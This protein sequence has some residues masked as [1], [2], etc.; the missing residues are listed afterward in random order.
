MMC[1]SSRRRTASS[2][3][4]D[5]PAALLLVEHPS[6]RAVLAQVP[7]LFIIGHD[8]AG[9][10]GERQGEKILPLLG[11]AAVQM[12]LRGQLLNPFTRRFY[13]LLVQALRDDGVISQAAPLSD[14]VTG[15]RQRQRTASL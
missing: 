4:F 15:P 6:K 14:L 13:H 11:I 2:N 5:N 1:S 10:I 3:R 12:P 9:Y 8:R 7:S